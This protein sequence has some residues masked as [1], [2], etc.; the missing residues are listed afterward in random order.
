MGPASVAEPLTLLAAYQEMDHEKF[1]QMSQQGTVGRVYQVNRVTSP[2][3]GQRSIV[4]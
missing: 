3:H 2:V 4:Q 1:N